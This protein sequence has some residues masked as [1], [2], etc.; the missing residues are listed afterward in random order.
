MLMTT[1]M[2]SRSDLLA[3]LP[4]SVAAFYIET[5][6]IAEVGV[7][8]DG[9]IGRYGLLLPNRDEPDPAIEALVRQIQLAAAT[10]PS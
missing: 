7:Q 3:V 10:G 4:R 5:G 1:V 2:I 8:L 9:F 6:L